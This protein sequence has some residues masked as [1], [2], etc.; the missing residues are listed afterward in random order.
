MTFYSSRV[1]IA[2][3]RVLA[4]ETLHHVDDA[5]YEITAIVYYTLHTVRR[6]STTRVLLLHQDRWIIWIVTRRK[7]Q[8]PRPILVMSCSCCW[9]SSDRGNLVQSDCGRRVITVVVSNHVQR[10]TNRFIYNMC[11]VINNNTF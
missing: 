6:P 5:R 10:E 9:C 4:A 8:T 1:M 11:F 2:L 7:R 3:A